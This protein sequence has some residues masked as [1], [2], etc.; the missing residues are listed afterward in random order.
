M[1]AAGHADMSRKVAVQSRDDK[2]KRPKAL[3]DIFA[4]VTL[5]PSFY[6]GAAMLVLSL[7]IEPDA[8]H[9][10]TIIAPSIA[11]VRK[12]IVRFIEAPCP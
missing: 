6:R 10:V 8:L 9:P 11:S 1:I 5:L 7:L 3:I 2:M 12:V 4:F